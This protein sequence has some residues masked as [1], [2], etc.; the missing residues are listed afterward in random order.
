[1]PPES[2]HADPR[3]RDA[4]LAL[5]ATASTR[6]AIVARRLRL[7]DGVLHRTAAAVPGEADGDA[8]DAAL[9]GAWWYAAHSWPSGGPELGTR[10]RVALLSGEAATPPAPSPTCPPWPLAQPA[11]LLLDIGL[12]QHRTSDKRATPAVRSPA[13]V[14]LSAA[15]ARDWLAWLASLDVAIVVGSDAWRD[16]VAVGTPVLHLDRDALAP[17]DAT[18]ARARQVQTDPRALLIEQ[19][20]AL[21]ALLRDE[22][23]WPDSIAGLNRVLAAAGRAT[24]DGLDPSATVLPPLRSETRAPDRAERRRQRA[25]RRRRK[26]AKLRQ[27]PRRFAVD[28]W[29]AR[30][31]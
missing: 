13:H 6:D 25:A 18:P 22:A 28:A 16:A 21:L 12:G 27:S 1:V 14:D 26:L 23:D 19:R 15:S 3:V 9:C 2:A 10:P 31:R 30:T 8:L 17:F 29:R 24:I 5:G 11:T 7:P 20:D 4:L